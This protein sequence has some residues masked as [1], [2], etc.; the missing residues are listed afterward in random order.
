MANKIMY[1]LKNVHYAKL[2]EVVDSSGQTTYSYGAVKAWPG[3]VSLSLEPQ[4]DVLK[5]YADDIEWYVQESNNGYEG[6]FEYEVMP[7]DFRE[8]ILGETKDNKNVFI[9]SSNVSTT[10]FALLFEVNGDTAKRRNLFYKCS[11][12]REKN[13]NSTKGESI[14]AS[15]GTITITAISRADGKVKASTGENVDTSTYNNWY[16]TVYETGGSTPVIT[17]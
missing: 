3:A 15:H 14:E 6:D 10:Y 16:N 2:T 13:D 11:A 1:G 17:T 8:N 12:T 4:S 7:E 5:E 9:E